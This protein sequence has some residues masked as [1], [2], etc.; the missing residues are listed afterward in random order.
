MGAAAEFS[1]PDPG[2]CPVSLGKGFHFVFL[3]FDTEE[4]TALLQDTAAAKQNKPLPLNTQNKT[5]PSSAAVFPGENRGTV[6]LS[7]RQLA[8]CGPSAPERWSGFSPGEQPGTSGGATCVRLS[9]VGK[10][11][12]AWWEGNVLQKRSEVLIGEE[13][14]TNGRQFPSFYSVNGCIFP[15]DPTT[16][17]RNTMIW[18]LKTACAGEVESVAVG[19][20]GV[21]Q[22]CRIP[23]PRGCSAVVRVSGVPHPHVYP[24]PQ[25]SPIVGLYHPVSGWDP[26]P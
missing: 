12:N 19:T 17:T 15:L 1:L 21:R 9:T 22:K 24:D 2:W 3:V 4:K 25:K 5:L 26:V 23:G 16:H 11:G 18:A 10:V 8:V 13:R 14:N 7:V 20:L 6:G